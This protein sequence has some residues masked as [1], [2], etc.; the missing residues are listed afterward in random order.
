MPTRVIGTDDVV[1]SGGLITRLHTYTLATYT[2]A[3]TS[4]PAAGDYVQN[5]TAAND[6]VVIAANDGTNVMIGRVKAAANT[7]D[8]TCVVEWLNVFAFVE[9]PIDDLSTATLGNAAIKDGATTVVANFD[10]GAAVGNMIV[11][12]KSGTSGAGTICCAVLVIG[13]QA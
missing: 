2:A 10:A 8:L 12:S 11:V 13:I 3:G 1:P 6:A 9:L 5:G 7:T 4:A